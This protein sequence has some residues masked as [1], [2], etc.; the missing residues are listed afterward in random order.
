[1]NDKTNKYVLIVASGG[2]TGTRFFGEAM[3]EVIEDCVSFHE[4]DVLTTN[5]QSNFRKIQ[6]FGFYQNFL[7]KLLDR[8]GLRAVGLKA[9]AGQITAE[10]A[11]DEISLHRDRFYARQS[12][13]LVVDSSLQW[14][15]LLNAVPLAMSN[16]KA[17]CVIRDPRSW[18]S[19]AENWGHWWASS[20]DW[21]RKLGRLRLTPCI[22]GEQANCSRW[23]SM[24]TFEKLCWSWTALN[25]T[26][27][28]AAGRHST[29]RMFRFEDLFHSEQ[30]KANMKDMLEFA[31][32][33]SD[34]A[35]RFNLER[36]LSTSPVNTSLGRSADEW[37]G[38]SSS[39]CRI[40]EQHCGP[41]MRLFGYGDEPEWNKRV[42][43]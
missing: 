6:Q 7:G 5:L 40:L 15:G 41:L 3:G 9:M 24:T 27:F 14:F 26:M 23:R 11:A 37:R 4:P 30:R 25:R 16:V 22:L 36:L 29:I 2:R 19:S 12:A 17:I 18:V 20:Q 38:W 13:S 39:R 31:T 1:M 42:R 34:K 32:T 43:S 28:D 10:A 21:V 33:F 35:F 8:T